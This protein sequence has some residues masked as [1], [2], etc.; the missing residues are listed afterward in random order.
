MCNP[1]QS[2]KENTYPLYYS[3]VLE[4]WKQ[5]P[6]AF[7]APVHLQAFISNPSSYDG[8]SKHILESTVIIPLFSNFFMTSLKGTSFLV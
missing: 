2:N 6:F 3:R 4:Y 5:W 7:P 8:A 1:L